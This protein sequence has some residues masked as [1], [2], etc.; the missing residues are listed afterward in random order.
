MGVEDSDLTAEKSQMAPLNEAPL[1][2][3]STIS[4]RDNDS[5]LSDNMPKDLLVVG[6]ERNGGKL[7]TALTTL[8]GFPPHT[9]RIFSA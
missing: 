2:G 5:G 3:T 1:D 4:C 6:N 7:T 8:F 9:L